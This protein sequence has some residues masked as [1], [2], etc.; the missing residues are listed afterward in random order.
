MGYA[1]AHGVANALWTIVEAASKMRD[2]N[3][4]F[5]LV[6]QGANK[7]ELENRAKALGV[8]NILFLP[9]VA[10]AS[11]PAL[12]EEFD[13]L[14]L[15][16]QR[17]PLFRFGVSPNKLI[18]YMMAGKP[19]ISAIEAG[20]DMVSDARCG[21]SIA[22][23]DP[24]ALI[25]AIERLRELTVAER[26]NLGQSGRRYVLAKHVYSVLSS[27]FLQVLST[28]SSSPRRSANAG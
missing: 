17:Q 20:N 13:V 28:D 16:L 2:K 27:R 14:Y 24:L 19:I 18:D 25:T 10:K 15:G 11:I 8:P 7:A 23:E 21:T 5:V 22:S 26:Q 4:C 6:G 9:A 1:G 3:V 12:L